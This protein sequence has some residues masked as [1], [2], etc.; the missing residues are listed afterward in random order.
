MGMKR[1][2]VRGECSATSEQDAIPTYRSSSLCHRTTISN[3]NRYQ[4]ITR[5]PA[6]TVRLYS[7]Y[8]GAPQRS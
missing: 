1:E 2:K 3:E 8:W 4:S 5:K 7:V 6:L